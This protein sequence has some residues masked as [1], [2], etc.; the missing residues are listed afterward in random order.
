VNVLLD[1]H[2]FVFW[3]EGSSKLTREQSRLIERATDTG[4]LFVSEISFWEIALLVE[5]DRLEFPTPVDEWLERAVAT[6]I[7]CLGITPRIASELASLST[8]RKWD[9]ADRIITATARVF[10]ARLVTN[11]SRIIDSRLVQTV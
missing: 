10:G 11:D 8:T 7:Q 4:A 3:A 2:T 1:T 6:D 9:P 5:V